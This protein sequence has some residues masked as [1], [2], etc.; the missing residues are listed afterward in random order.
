MYFW[1]H[2]VMQNTKYIIM[3]SQKHAKVHVFYMGMGDMQIDPCPSG[4]YELT[5]PLS[6]VIIKSYALG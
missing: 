5:H 4:G 6:G 2:A 1:M 3:A